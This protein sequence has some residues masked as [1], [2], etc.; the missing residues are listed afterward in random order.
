MIGWYV[1][2]RVHKKPS[3]VLV[4]S[5]GSWKV[6]DGVRETAFFFFFLVVLNSA[7][8]VCISNLKE[9]ERRGVKEGG[10]GGRK[11]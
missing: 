1:S 3:T 2:G 6:R 8:S 10:K 4:S 9:R 5:E 7:P 11:S